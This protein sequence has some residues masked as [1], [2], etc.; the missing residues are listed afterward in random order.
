MLNSMR[1]K[2]A[3]FGGALMSAGLACEVV[4]ADSIFDVTQ[5]L[6]V[7]DN[8]G[9]GGVFS[10]TGYQAYASPSDVAGGSLLSS[11]NMIRLESWFDQSG[12]NAYSYITAGVQFE[13]ARTFE[14]TLSWNMTG[15]AY[16]YFTGLSEVGFGYLA[17]PELDGNVFSGTVTLEQGRVYSLSMTSHLL[18]SGDNFIQLET[19]PSP[20]VLAVLGLGGIINARRRRRR[21][22]LPRRD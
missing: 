5:N 8:G 11:P 17:S 1:M 22:A 12:G 10:E 18:S 15:D 21:G 9:G 3:L 20:G 2:T 13:V 19:I 6:L 7:W 4:S 16:N 14:A